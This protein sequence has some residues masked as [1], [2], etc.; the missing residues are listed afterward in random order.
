MPTPN[1]RHSSGP[2]N[3][4]YFENQI[5]LADRQRVQRVAISI[6]SHVAQENRLEH[7]ARFITDSSQIFANIEELSIVAHEV[8][9]LYADHCRLMTRPYNPK[10]TS[11]SF[12]EANHTQY[13][14][15]FSRNDTPRRQRNE[16][17]R[18]FSTLVQ[19]KAH[20]IWWLEQCERMHASDIVSLLD[21]VI[22]Q[23]RSITFQSNII[24][25][26]DALSKTIG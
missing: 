23:E 24:K 26:F 22:S 3:L 11:V 12:C 15:N 6:S 13:L 5:S 1:E 16:T 10:A 21:P 9:R 7:I 25:A 14:A 17:W 20:M 2:C 18:D 4:S 19:T 8:D